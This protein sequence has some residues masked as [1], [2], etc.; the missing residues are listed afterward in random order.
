MATKPLAAILPQNKQT[1]NP[2]TIEQE[3]R[4]EEVL[5]YPILLSDRV[6]EDVKEAK[7]FKFECLEVGK[8]VGNLCQML[9]AAVRLSTSTIAGISFYD[10]PL[11]RITTGVSKNLEKSLALLKKCK[12]R[13]SCKCKYNTLD[14]EAAISPSKLKPFSSEDKAA[15]K[16]NGISYMINDCGLSP[17][18]AISTSENVHF[19]SPERPDVVLNFL[20]QNGFSKSQI[21]EL[22]QK[23]P[24]ILLSD[25]EKTRLPKIEFL[26][27]WTGVTKADVLRS[28]AR[29]PTFLTR[30]VENQLIPIY[31]YLKDIIGAE[32]VAT[33][34]RRS[35]W[36][37]N[38]TFAKRVIPNVDFL[39]ALDIP[40][41]F[42]TLVL[43]NFSRSHWSKTQPVQRNCCRG[44]GNEI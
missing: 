19:D 27:Q 28:I 5:S 21:A 1:K 16:V 26:L 42:I 31:N 3:K 20:A 36:I 14:S 30:I 10:C 41:S 24:S 40:N 11:R 2:T 8:K 7:S 37:F 13:S 43:F 22:V 44:E 35:S 12:R 6:D 29:D 32:K 17:E 33:L 34:V 18:I 4:I 23:R 9:R 38:R 39:R 15:E 25:P